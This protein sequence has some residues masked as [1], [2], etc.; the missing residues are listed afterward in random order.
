MTGALDRFRSSR[1]RA[2]LTGRWRLFRHDAGR[3]A[4]PPPWAYVA[5]FLTS[6]AIGPWS[7]AAFGAVAVWLSNGVMAAALLQLHRRPALAVIGVCFV[8]N[9]VS[10]VLRGGSAVFLWLNAVLNVGEAM[11][12]AVLARRVCGAA[13]DMRR[14]GRL[15]RFAHLAVAPAMGLS[16]VIA[17]GVMYLLD[18]VAPAVLL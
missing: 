3:V 10:K 12:A 1:A 6:L 17:I 13:L 14:P 7:A 18:P 2:G 11:L 16:A 8:A 9:V 4:G 5:L 15:A